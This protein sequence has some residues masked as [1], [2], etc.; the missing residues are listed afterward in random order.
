MFR[1]VFT[2][3]G[4]ASVTPRIFEADDAIVAYAA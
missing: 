3:G 1:R 4:N 2:P